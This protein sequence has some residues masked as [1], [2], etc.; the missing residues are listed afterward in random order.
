M[1]VSS[2]D[3][4]NASL[5]AKGGRIT[6]V[7]TYEGLNRGVLE[8]FINTYR[9]ELDAFSPKLIYERFFDAFADASWRVIAAKNNVYHFKEEPKG[10]QES[11]FCEYADY[12]L[13]ALEQGAKQSKDSTL[14]LLY[15]ARTVRSSLEDVLGFASCSE[16]NPFLADLHRFGNLSELALGVQ[17]TLAHTKEL[18]DSW[19]FY[20]RKSSNFAELHLAVD[21]LARVNDMNFKPFS[22]KTPEECYEQGKKNAQSIIHVLKKESSVALALD[23]VIDDFLNT[24]D[25]EVF[26]KDS[27]LFADDMFKG[28]VI[29]Q[30]RKKHEIQ[31]RVAYERKILREIEQ[32]TLLTYL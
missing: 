23:A 1:P 29:S 24:V 15:A 12:V 30:I 11:L 25:A 7:H 26:S 9:T 21:M 2:L 27:A 3:M 16:K 31:D 28:F 6:L 5:P 22:E 10:V 17:E 4:N 8:R 20:A 14:L 19:V 13:N 18:A 32:D